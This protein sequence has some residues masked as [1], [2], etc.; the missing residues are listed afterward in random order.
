[1][2]KRTKALAFAIREI[3]SDAVAPPLFTMK[4]AWVVEIWAPPIGSTLR[5]A[6]SISWPAKP[7]GGFF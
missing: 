2:R 7:P 1:M 3:T 6:A 4:F 5:P